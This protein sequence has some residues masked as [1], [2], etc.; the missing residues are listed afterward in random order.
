MFVRVRDNPRASVMIPGGARRTNNM[1]GGGES[2]WTHE[3]IREVVIA[4]MRAIGFFFFQAEDGIRDLTVTGVQTCALPILPIVP[5]GTKVA[6]A[7]PMRSAATSISRLAV[8][9]SPKTSSPSGASTIA[10]R[11]SGLGIDRKSVV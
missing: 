2:G 8:G 4:S 9:S 5:L 3:R 1:T 6:A 11:I 7:F 10:R